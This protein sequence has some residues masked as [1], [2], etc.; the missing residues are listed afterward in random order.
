M[1]LA[2]AKILGW[3]VNKSFKFVIKGNSKYISKMLR[4]YMDVIVILKNEKDKLIITIIRNYT[5][6]NNNES[7]L[8]L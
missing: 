1:N 7:K 3:K 4:W 6:I 5:Y 8:I 2:T